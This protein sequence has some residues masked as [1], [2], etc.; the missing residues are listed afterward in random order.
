MTKRYCIIFQGVLAGHERFRQRME[1]LG[2]TQE[3]IER[4][5]SRAP[6][7]VKDELTLGE[8][9]RYSDLIR[10]AGGR[11]AIYD[12]GWG[13]GPV[14]RMGHPWSVAHLDKFT[15]CPRCGLKHLKVESCPRCGFVK[16]EQSESSKIG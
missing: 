9:R 6:L 16:C 12:R 3:V 10:E 13:E 11:V 4:M 2:A 15:P 14:P 1:A 7:V 8:A 5:M